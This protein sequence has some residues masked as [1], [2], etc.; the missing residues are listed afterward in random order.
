MA[1][2]VA[3]L[4]NVGTQRGSS[5]GRRPSFHHETTDH[6]MPDLPAMINFVKRTATGK[7]V[8]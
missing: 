4:V 3:Y 2:I 6:A 8:A 5:A 7:R 1:T